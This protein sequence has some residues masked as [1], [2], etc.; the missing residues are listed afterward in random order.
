MR[1]LL[2]LTVLVVGACA[3]TGADHSLHVRAEGCD[4]LQ[5]DKNAELEFEK[6]GELIDNE[7]PV[8]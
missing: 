7:V 3:V 1:Y 4:L 2:I 8:P 6:E 5:L